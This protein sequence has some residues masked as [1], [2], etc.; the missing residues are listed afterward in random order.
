VV[1]LNGVIREKV[2]LGE[3]HRKEEF[4][5]ELGQHVVYRH[6]QNKYRIKVDFWFKYRDSEVRCYQKNHLFSTWKRQLLPECD[7]TEGRAFR[8]MLYFIEIGIYFGPVTN[9]AIKRLQF[10][11]EIRI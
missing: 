9:G 5:N 7:T 2:Y 6:S 8:V 3:G 10:N 1:Q 4:I 11:C